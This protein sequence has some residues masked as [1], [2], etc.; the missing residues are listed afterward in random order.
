MIVFEVGDMTCGHCV[1]TITRV[2]QALDDSARVQIDL[3]SRRVAIESTRASAA[4]LQA[5]IEEAGYTPV[6]AG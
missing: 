6:P 5:A 3:P 1:G 4:Q 2:V